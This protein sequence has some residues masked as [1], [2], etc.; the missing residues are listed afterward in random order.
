MPDRGYMGFVGVTTGSSSIMR[1]FPAWAEE[2]CLPTRTIIGHD[3]SPNA[4]REVYRSL[5]CEIRDDPRHFGAL[6]TTHKMNVFESARDLFD[7]ID[8]LATVFGEVSSIAKRGARLT[9]A[10]KDPITVRLAYEEFIDDAYFARTG[11]HVLCLGS[12]GSGSALVHQLAGRTDRPERIVITARRQVKLDEVRE[13]IERSGLDGGGIEYVLAPDPELAGELLAT[14]PSGSVV[15]NSTGMGK[16]TP[17][18]PLSAGA[19]FPDEAIAW[20]FNYRGTLEFV[21]QAQA[22]QPTR[23]LHVVDGWR[24]F[25]HGWSQVVA[26]VFDISMPPERVDR[27]AEIA[28]GLR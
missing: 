9:A 13:L 12:G 21:H 27:L 24:Y 7:D 3:V 22:Q 14:M 4:P 10:A 15:A 6:V 16:D 25:I 18:S 5:V 2:L 28:D 8:P 1:I 20:D 17:G 26:D 19:R 23:S 11:A